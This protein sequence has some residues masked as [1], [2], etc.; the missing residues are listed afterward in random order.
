[1]EVKVIGTSN[2]NYQAS[3][4]ELDLSGGKSAGICYSKNPFEHLLNESEETTEKRI[5]RTKKWRT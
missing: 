1:M 5:E 4:R 3:K 2:L